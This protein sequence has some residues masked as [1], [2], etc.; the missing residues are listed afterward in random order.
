MNASLSKKILIGVGSVVALVVAVG[1]W[2]RYLRASK[3][4]RN[5]STLK[6]DYELLRHETPGTPVD[7]IG[8]ALHRLNSYR[9]PEGK[10]E[11]LKRIAD[12]RPQVRSAVADALGMHPLKG[13][14][15]ESEIRLMADSDEGVRVA[16]L[17]AVSRSEDSRKVDLL[18]GVIK[19]A[20]AGA[21]EVMEAH[22]GL[23]RSAK[24]AERDAHVKAIRELLARNQKDSAMSVQGLKILVRLDPSDDESTNLIMETFTA[25]GTSR[26]ILP[27]LYRYLIRRRPEVLKKR[28]SQ[29]VRSGPIEMRVTALNSILELCPPDRWNAIHTVM[30]DAKT[31]PQVKS[32]V[33]RIVQ[34]LGGKTKPDGSFDKPAPGAD[35]CDLRTK[36]PAAPHGR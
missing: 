10:T 34:F 22:A 5:N 33:A 15:I 21:R 14:I 12:P 25:S 31:E 28:F 32:L 1:V 8:I 27:S 9:L 7:S 30:T 29:D 13:E 18:N 26:Q 17:N 6:R 3:E 23:A 20:S 16:A 19:N 2:N 24:G 35:R 11:A 4:I 36:A